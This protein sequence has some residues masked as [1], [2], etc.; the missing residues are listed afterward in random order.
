MVWVGVGIFKVGVGVGVEVF[1]V[2]VGVGDKVGVG[3]WEFFAFEGNFS[4]GER[5][6]CGIFRGLIIRSLVHI[7]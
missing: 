6:F 2:G 7:V 5:I 1:K 4:W 3:G